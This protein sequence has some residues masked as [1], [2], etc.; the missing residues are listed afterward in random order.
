MKVTTRTTLAVLTVLA[1]LFVVAPGASAHPSGVS[2]RITVA[3]SDDVV[4]VRWELLSPHELTLLAVHLGLLPAE[5]VL[6]DGAVEYEDGDEHV[7]AGDPAFTAYALEHVAVTTT[8][9]ACTGTA[10]PVRDLLTDGV[11]LAFA[12]PGSPRTATVLADPLTDIDPAY[13]ALGVGPD[14]QRAVYSADDA[15]HEWTLRAGVGAW[16]W[17][18]ATVVALAGALTAARLLRRT[19]RPQDAPVPAPA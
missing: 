9:G 1:T 14:G 17:L 12:C 15:E 8:D 6:L 3:A 18:A 19:Q 5:R 16:L 2:Q 7:L 4:R 10:E 11:V 13:Q